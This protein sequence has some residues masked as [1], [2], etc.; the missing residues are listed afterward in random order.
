VI[1]I[2]RPE[3]TNQN[4]LGNTFFNMNQFQDNFSANDMFAD[5]EQQPPVTADAE[6]PDVVDEE[7]TIDVPEEIA[8]T[9]EEMELLNKMIV[10]DTM[11]ESEMDEVRQILS[12]K[13]DA[14]KKMMDESIPATS[15]EESS[16]HQLPA[17]PTTS[18]GQLPSELKSSPVYPGGHS[19]GN[20]ASFPI[21]LQLPEED[22]PKYCINIKVEV[23]RMG[24]SLAPT[25]RNTP[26]CV[27][28]RRRRY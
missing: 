4:G 24:R 11:T 12:T 7:A 26:A 21:I 1:N 27:S 18:S 14:M 5:I 13:M 23:T 19:G 15:S 22:C 6:K 2:Q 16:S 28:Q 20:L 10:S 3:D 9:D 17:M 25:C 8:M